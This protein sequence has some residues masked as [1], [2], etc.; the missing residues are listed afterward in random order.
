MDVLSLSILGIVTGS[1]A[2]LLSAGGGMIIFPMLHA[3]YPDLTTHAIVTVCLNQI[4]CAG[5]VAYA[6][7]NRIQKQR[8]IS[9][10]YKL[11]YFVIL[12]V[13]TLYL[14]WFHVNPALISI[15]FILFLGIGLT[16]RLVMKLRVDFPFNEKHI[17]LS[18]IFT[19]VYGVTVGMGGSLILYP[20]LRIGQLS[21][22]KTLRLCAYNAFS[23]GLIGAIAHNLSYVLEIKDQSFPWEILSLILITSSV[24]SYYMAQYAYKL[25]GSTIDHL[26]NLLIASIIVF[27]S[28]ELYVGKL[29]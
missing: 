14:S 16:L 27:Y 12:I 25:K 10:P 1:V 17:L 18:L 19:S 9:L 23:V 15:L 11:V 29:H 13:M 2:G 24:T 8:I 6:M 28:Y 22:Q 7:H 5:F 20:L 21:P 3:M 26:S 4:L